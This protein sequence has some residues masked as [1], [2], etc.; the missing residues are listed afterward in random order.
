MMYQTK[1][2]IK[3]L[4]V[5]LGALGMFVGSLGLSC[6]PTNVEPTNRAT[7][8]RATTNRA[9]TNLEATNVN[10]P[11]EPNNNQVDN[12]IPTIDNQTNRANFIREYLANTSFKTKL[13]TFNNLSKIQSVS[14]VILDKKDG[15]VQ[16]LLGRERA[17]DY[18]GKLNFI[19][20]KCEQHDPKN[21][22]ASVLATL[23]D[24]V[25]EEL[26][27]QLQYD[28]FAKSLIAL[29]S[30][31]NKTYNTPMFFCYISDLSIIEWQNM[32]KKRLAMHHLDWKYQEF[33]EIKFL[34]I[35]ALSV[36]KDDISTYVY[37]NIDQIIAV[38]KDMQ[39]IGVPSSAFPLVKD[40]IPMMG[41]K[42]T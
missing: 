21:P 41:F 8:N 33:S 25:R 23:Y 7:T 27:I 16:V 37:E 13:N 31:A 15:K 11:S 38:S 2:Y 9:T 34:P 12:P 29:K 42:S 4:L 30:P 5:S 22:L 14:C 24:E 6:R 36:H 18:T 40:N 17:G 35:E 1:L 26:G 10:L 3:Q 32:H 20:G 28:A 19:G 39:D